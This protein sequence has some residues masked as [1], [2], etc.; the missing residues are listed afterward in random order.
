M[1][2]LLRVTFWLTIA[3][4]LLPSFGGNRSGAEA[5]IAA[6]DAFAAAGAVVSD[7]SSFCTR[8]PDACVVGT[9]AAVAIGARAQEGVRMVYDFVG[10]H[11]AKTASNDPADKTGSVTARKLVAVGGVPTSQN[12]LTAS[13]LEPAWQGPPSRTES[14]PLPRKNPHRRT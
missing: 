14:V 13:D 10:D 8:Q 2:F 6:S 3:L 1:F 7:V 5:K 4:A 11:T 9:Q 12:T